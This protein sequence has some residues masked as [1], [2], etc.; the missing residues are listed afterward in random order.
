MQFMCKNYYLEWKEKRAVCE[1]YA[2]VT[3]THC[4]WYDTCR[5]SL[6][7]S[8]HVSTRLSRELCVAAVNHQ[9]R[10]VLVSNTCACLNFFGQVNYICR[11]T[12]SNG[13]VWEGYSPIISNLRNDQCRIHS[14]SVHHRRIGRLRLRVDI[15]A[16]CEIIN[17]KELEHVWWIP[18]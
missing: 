2:L 4:V 17:R 7:K 6:D 9:F 10:R 16:L 14:I 18:T 15:F 8:V 5:S 12:V 1:I 13:I 11:N 3:C